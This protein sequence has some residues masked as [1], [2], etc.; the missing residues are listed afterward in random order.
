MNTYGRTNS[1]PMIENN[2][3]IPDEE[4]LKLFKNK[5]AV[6]R[7]PTKTIHEIIPRSRATNWR[8]FVNRIPLCYICHDKAHLRIYSEGMLRFIREKR[9]QEYATVE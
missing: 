8:I 2:A 4:I 5:C 7:R 9:L 3:V 1:S 6:C